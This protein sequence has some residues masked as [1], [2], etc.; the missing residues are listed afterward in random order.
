MNEIYDFVVI[1]SGFGGSVSAMRLTQKGYRVA[2]LEAGKRYRANDFPKT[3]WD[4]R[5][6]LWLPLLRCFGFQKISLVRGLMLL[7]GV[8]VGGGSLVYANTL[9]RPRADVFQ[10][11]GWP[12][13]V[14]WEKELD[15]HFEEAKRMLGVVRN[16]VLDASEDALRK[17]AAAMNAEDSFHPT[18]VGVFFG[19]PEKKVADPYFSG[20]GPD[21]AGCNSCGGCLV[22]CRHL[23]KNTLDLN[24]LYFAEKWGARMS[25]ETRAERISWTPSGEAGRV[26]RIETSRST[27]WIPRKGPEYLARNVILASGVLGTLKLLFR[28]SQELQTLQIESHRLGQ[29]VRVN[30]ESLT[31]A[32]SVDA[33]RDFSRGIAIGAAMHPNEYTKVESVRYPAGSGFMRLMAVPFA[34]EGS[35]LTRPLKMGVRAL[36]R[37]SRT[38]RVLLVRDWARSS[39]IL[40]AMQSIDQ[41]LRL[42]YGRS[43]LTAW[44]KGIVGSKTDRPIPS[45]LPLAQAAAEKLAQEIDGEPLNSAAEV[46]LGTPLTAHIL[47]GCG[48][49]LT[50]NDGVVSPSHE[51]FGCPGLYVVDGSTIPANLGVNPSLTIAALAERFSAGWPEKP[52]VDSDVLKNRRIRFGKA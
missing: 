43:W 33:R 40:L 46:L 5:R 35:R 2:V 10:D 37:L 48:L 18:E 16:P 23:A 7:H 41:T 25:A 26:Y 51:V 8:G 50:P 32:V 38:L 36:S 52:G 34:P 29:G 39:V 42:T 45:Y 49:G 4:V 14:D 3:N 17:V 13:G 11:S 20:A 30:G 47:G 6:Y 31:G 12:R 9:M 15:P 24:Y 19:E 22:G 1:G 44:R 28:N 21:R 27:S